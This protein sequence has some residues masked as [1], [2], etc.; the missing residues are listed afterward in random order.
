MGGFFNCQPCLVQS[1]QLHTVTRLGGGWEAACRLTQPDQW[2]LSA[3]QPGQEVGDELRLRQIL[4]QVLG[5]GLL[6][7][8][9]HDGLVHALQQVVK[10]FDVADEGLLVEILVAAP[11]WEGE[12]GHF[13]RKKRAVFVDLDTDRV[14]SA[15]FCGILAK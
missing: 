4:R 6:P 10:L 14:G 8:A 1:Q 9:G 2:R 5:G 13:S 15:S 12:N 11:G 7:A 3:G